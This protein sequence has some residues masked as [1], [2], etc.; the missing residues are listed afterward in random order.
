M[1]RITRLQR[2]WAPTGPVHV[3][4]T[5]GYILA[6]A[7]A[8]SAGACPERVGRSPYGVTETVVAQGNLAYL[9]N[10]AALMAIDLTDA[11]SP[12]I[13]SEVDLPYAI[14][15]LAIDGDRVYA[16][17]SHHLHVIDVSSPSSPLELGALEFY[18]EKLALAASGS[19][20]CFSGYDSL[21]V[22]DVSDP[23]SPVVQAT[24]PFP[25]Y[26]IEL[27]G[28]YAYV[29]SGGFRVLDLTDPTNPT[30]VAYLEYLNG[31]VEVVGRHAYVAGSGLEIIDIADPL[32]P[33]HLSH[34]ELVGGTQTEVAVHGKLAFLSSIPGPQHVVGISDPMAPL[35]LGWILTP[36][37]WA[38]ST[39]VAA[40]AGRG[41]FA[42]PF[43]GL[44]VVDATDPTTPVEVSFVDGPG[45]S[46]KAAFSNDVLFVAADER[47]LR[48]VDVS[49]SSQP[50]DLGFFDVDQYD[51]IEGVDVVGNLAVV[52]P[53]FKV[54]DVS[55]P[56]S[57]ILVGE[58]PEIHSGTDV[59]VVGTLAYVAD[60]THGLR[61]VDVSDPTT[62]VEVGDLLLGLNG[63]TIELS[64]RY[65][66]L[67]VGTSVD[68]VDVSEPTSPF[69]V[70][71]ADPHGYG[72][73]F[74][75]FETYL[76]VPERDRLHV[77]DLADPTDPLEIAVHTI[78]RLIQ[79]IGIS[80]SVAYLGTYGDG[81]E[82]R[83][84]AWDISDPQNL[85]FMGAQDGAGILT[86]LVFSREHVYSIR[87]NSGFDIFALYQG[88]IFADGFETGDTQM[89]SIVN[90]TNNDWG[91]R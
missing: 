51:S 78:P 29:T 10:G 9:G 49:D 60:E 23:S 44:R 11:T 36:A 80:G 67:R 7:G 89:W 56:A 74:G 53:R 19:L 28:G 70:A 87:W 48:A 64:G 1:N 71:R 69:L 76:L 33:S 5:I 63:K 66:F 14:Q 40:A 46:I 24:A 90:T 16:G 65:A 8:A 47:G 77:F 58:L 35:S 54:L 30:Q 42:T 31:G 82:A 18:G 6:I 88:P 91:G 2:I 3:A 32:N 27:V 68:I 26:G 84:E 62:P 75:L 4:L 59:A 22:L 34:L 15:S 39:D 61:I 12:E 41:L 37:W 25:S 52:V 13:I 17:T 86:D 55:D 20:V 57:P 85:V 50:V 73:G 45:K 83:F 21:V 81:V 38:G 43:H 72:N 79:A